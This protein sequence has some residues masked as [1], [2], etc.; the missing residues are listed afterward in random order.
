VAVTTQVPFVGVW[1]D[2]PESLLIARSELRH[3]DASDADAAVIRGQ[4]AQGAGAINWHRIDASGSLDG[5]LRAVT[6]MLRERLTSEVVRRESQ[7]A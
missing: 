1:L 4:L 2:V 6:D 7:A 3:L 5:V